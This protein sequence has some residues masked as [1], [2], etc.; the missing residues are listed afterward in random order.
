MGAVVQIGGTMTEFKN[1]MVELIG[2][3]TQLKE[4]AI[5]ARM[6]GRLTARDLVILQTISRE[7][8]NLIERDAANENC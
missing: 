2:L 1:D 4:I 5:V 3:S 6:G 8:T 7:I